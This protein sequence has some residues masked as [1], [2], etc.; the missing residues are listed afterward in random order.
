MWESASGAHMVCK[1]EAVNTRASLFQA[2]AAGK[3]GLG[4]LKIRIALGA[5]L[6]LALAGCGN[7]AEEADDPLVGTGEEGAA[8][9]AADAPVDASISVPNTGVDVDQADV[10][11]D[12]PGDPQAAPAPPAAMPAATVPATPPPARAAA[13]TP[14]RVFTMCSACHSI[15]PGEH[16]IGP[17]LAGIFGARAASKEGFRYSQALKDSGLVWNEANLDR[18]LANPRATVPGTTMVFAGL[19]DAKRRQEVMDYMKGL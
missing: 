6:A 8:P 4:G 11:A 5:T 2:R 16:G 1:R 19:R 10:V 15:A 13:A 3:K 18:Y 9:W 7:P 12:E 17:S 14:P